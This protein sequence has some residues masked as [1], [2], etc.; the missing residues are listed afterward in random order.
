MVDFA[1]VGPAKIQATLD[2]VTNLE[3]PYKVQLSP[4][5]ATRITDIKVREGDQ[6]QIGQTLVQLDSSLARA[7]VLQADANLAEM[8]ARLSQAKLQQAP[9]AA[10]IYGQVANQ[11]AAVGSAHADTNQY[12]QNLNA[13]IAAAQA[14]KS[15]VQAKV[16]AAEAQVANAEASLAKEQSSLKNAEVKLNR[17]EELLKQG[18]VPAQ[19]VDDARTGRDVQQNSVKVAQAV[20][21]SVKQSL[22]SARAQVAVA[23][24]QLSIVKKKGEADI[25]ASR[26]RSV[27]AETSL[28]VAR[29][30][31]SQ[32]PAYQENIRALA[33]SVAVAQA[34][35]AQ[36]RANLAETSLVSTINGSVTARNGEVG[37]LASPGQPV[38]VVQYLKWLYAVSNVPLE[39]IGKC[40]EGMKVAVVIEGIQQPLEGVLSNINPSADP[41]SRQFSVRVKISNE[42]GK[43]RPGMIGKL[44][45]ILSETEAK[46]AVPKEALA[47][48]VKG[49]TV[50]VVGE[51]RKVEIRKVVVGSKDSAFVE[52][53]EGLKAGEK[54]VILSYTPLRDGSTVRLPGDPVPGSKDKGSG[55]KS[56]AGK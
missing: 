4:K 6:V 14:Q 31:L 9:S 38:L 28:T 40:H 1:V 26:A 52:V 54:V 16:L 21:A 18:F 23:E 8:R 39:A 51:D 35:L 11:R 41:I 50:T 19:N 45:L 7:A 55:E 42:S 3:S 32:N 48:Q 49:F 15:D 10:Q 24:N 46:I 25:A 34:Q 56:K 22:Q 33:S 13:Q 12:V 43:L 2:L 53:T 17:Q 44:K 20:V 37:S 5:A 27:Q 30:N 36:A 29:A 47:P